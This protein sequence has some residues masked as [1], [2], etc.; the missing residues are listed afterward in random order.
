MPK[1]THIRPFHAREFQAQQHERRHLQ[2]VRQHR[3]EHRHVQ[4]DRAD[5]AA[6]RR[7]VNRQRGR[8]AQSRSGQQRPL[9]R[10]ALAVRLGKPGRKIAG[11]RQRID[12]PA[13]RVD[14]GMET[15]DEP[16]AGGQRQGSR[17]QPAGRRCDWN[18]RN[19]GSLDRATCAAPGAM[20]ALKT[21]V[22][23]EPPI[24][25]SKPYRIARGRSCFGS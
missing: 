3:S 9:R 7:E 10:L 15:G 16:G 1:G 11:A 4:Q 6:L 14:D 25:V 23:K 24:S 19:S 5:G 18:P 12:L 2:H 21:T 8:V 17:L 22:R 20:P 13:V